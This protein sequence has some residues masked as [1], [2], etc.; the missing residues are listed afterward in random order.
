[1]PQPCSVTTPDSN[2]SARRSNI[3]CRRYLRI[4]AVS[5]GSLFLVCM[6]PGAFSQANNR[7]T[8][9]ALARLEPAN[10]LIAVG[11]PGV[12][13]QSVDVTAGVEVKAGQ[14]LATVVGAEERKAQLAVAKAQ[15]G[16]SDFEREIKRKQLALSRKQFDELQK[17]RIASQQEAISILENSLKVAEGDLQRLEQAQVA[18]QQINQQ[19]LFVNTTRGNLIEARLRLLELQLANQILPEQRALEDQSLSDD[20]PAQQVLLDQIRLAEAAFA[21]TQITAPS[22]G[23]VLQVLGHAGEA[24]SGPVL[25]LG[26][27]GKMVAIAEVYQK[28]IAGLKV[29]DAAEIDLFGKKIAGRVTRIGRMVGRNKMNSINP[30]APTDRRVVEVTILLDDAEQ[31]ARYVNMEVDATIFPNGEKSGP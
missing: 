21:Q 2:G 3:H 13:L 26:D 29:N 25:Y 23:V 7:T 28:D 16:A 1:M 12:R 22:D 5:L 9:N 18:R 30:I 4:V 10:G 17:S 31:A 19:Q 15:K 14:V 20:S 11:V 6:A 8:V 27:V 24:V